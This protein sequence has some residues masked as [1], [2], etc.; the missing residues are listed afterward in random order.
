MMPLGLCDFHASQ[1]TNV[2]QCD[3]AVRESK[4]RMQY[5]TTCSVYTVV[6]TSL[7]FKFEKGREHLLRLV[8]NYVLHRCDVD[9]ALVMG[10]PKVFVVLVAVAR[11]VGS[12][13]AI[14]TLLQRTLI[15]RHDEKNAGMN[16]LFQYILS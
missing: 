1:Y 12:D 13:Q 14:V 11:A 4:P 5:M 7:Y 2:Y 9:D 8:M 10:I 3:S 15:G 16:S 6:S